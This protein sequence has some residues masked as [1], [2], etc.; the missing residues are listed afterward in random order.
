LQQG[1]PNGHNP[2]KQL[3]ILKW[4]GWIETLLRTDPEKPPGDKDRGTIHEATAERKS[5]IV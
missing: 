4:S 5:A 1:V 2:I 3:Q